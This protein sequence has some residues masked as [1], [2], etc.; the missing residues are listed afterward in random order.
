MTDAEFVLRFFA[1]SSGW[2]TFKGELREELD[3]FMSENRFADVKRL[4]GL[5]ASF[6]QC[7]ETASAIWASDAF[8]RPGRDQSLAGLFD[9]QMIALSTLNE[10][11]HAALVRHRDDAVARANE[12]FSDPEF[13]ESVRRATNTPARL[14]LRTEMMV[15]ALLPVATEG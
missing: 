9:A 4:A 15:A 10:S 5:R 6:V 8:K 1:L 11:Q 7:I 14:R 12:L 3:R 2:R 13:D